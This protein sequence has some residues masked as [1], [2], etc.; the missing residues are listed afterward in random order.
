M[1]YGVH[2]ACHDLTEASFLLSDDPH[3]FVSYDGHPSQEEAVS[4]VTATTKQEW[5]TRKVIWIQL[6]DQ[7]RH[8]SDEHDK[9]AFIIH[10]GCYSLF[11]R[12]LLQASPQL[13]SISLAWTIAQSMS[14]LWETRLRPYEHRHR[15]S[16]I[17]YDAAASNHFLKLGDFTEATDP[18]S[19]RTFY[20]IQQL[21]LEL[22]EH[23]AG[24]LVGE[25][26]H[27]SLV[28]MQ[29]ISEFLPVADMG[30]LPRLTL[31]DLRRTIYV[32]R[33][34]VAGRH[35]VLRAANTPFTGSERILSPCQKRRLNVELDDF[36]VI[37]LA[38]VTSSDAK[39]TNT[40]RVAWESW[41]EILKPSLNSEDQVVTCVRKVRRLPTIFMLRYYLSL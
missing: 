39:E 30:K 16:A 21:P 25:D 40:R 15:R 18:A 29:M 19:A 8:F 13:D 17:L 3:K 2:G 34:K 22:R 10:A 41:Y 31:V 12:V 23:I 20:R 4:F 11:S 27:R 14:P 37:S 1:I 6:Y 32:C 5:N 33:R 7:I 36:G 38:D 28:V 26:V 9:F 24:Y 35:Y